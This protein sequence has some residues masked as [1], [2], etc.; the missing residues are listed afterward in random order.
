MDRVL[1]LSILKYDT[2]S[3]LPYDI[4]KSQTNK[5]KQTTCEWALK[6]KKAV[7][8]CASVQFSPFAQHSLSQFG[9]KSRRDW[10]GCYYRIMVYWSMK[11]SYLLNQCQMHQNR[12]KDTNT[13]RRW[14]AITI[15][16]NDLFI[17]LYTDVA[18][19]KPLDAV[20]EEA[21]YSEQWTTMSTAKSNDRKLIVRRWG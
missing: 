12:C 19:D 5:L 14:T 4:K 1:L 13:M 3:R 8:K 6:L 18:S 15:V 9:E 2:D 7:R 16:Y 21:D 11:G 20:V 17:Y 10:K